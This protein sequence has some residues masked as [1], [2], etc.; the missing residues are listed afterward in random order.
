MAICRYSNPL[1]PT[2]GYGEVTVTDFGAFVELEEGVR[3]CLRQEI[4]DHRIDK[5][6]DVLK[7]GDR[8][9]CEILT[10]EPKE[11]RI[12]LSIKQLGRTEERANYQTHMGDSNKKTTMGDIL[13]DKLKA[14]LKPGAKEEEKEE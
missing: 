14:A 10:I 12:G 6:A 2:T 7:A 9:R 13:G 11:R 3:A 1:S 5:P 4:A 8:V